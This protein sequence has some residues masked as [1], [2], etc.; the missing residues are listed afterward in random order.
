M[1]YL[2]TLFSD[3]N[4]VTVIPAGATNIDIRQLGY[5]HLRDDENYLGINITFSVVTELF[6]TFLDV[7]K[8]YINLIDFV[9]DV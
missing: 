3:Y 1:K 6:I 9:L 5:R 7:C 8:F 4:N 2:H